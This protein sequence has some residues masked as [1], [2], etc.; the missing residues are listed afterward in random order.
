MNFFLSQDPFELNRNVSGGFGEPGFTRF[1]YYCKKAEEIFDDLTNK[2][3][4][5][6]EKNLGSVQQSSL[7]SQFAFQCCN[8]PQLLK[9][10][11]NV[12]FHLIL[13]LNLNFEVFKMGFKWGMTAL[14]ILAPICISIFK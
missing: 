12:P 8:F 4:E 1:M 5:K 10:L 9:T 11:K 13:N 7:L 6:D 3:E 2:T 14:F